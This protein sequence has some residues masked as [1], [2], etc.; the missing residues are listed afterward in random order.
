MATRYCVKP[1]KG[2]SPLT[3]VST[4]ACRKLKVKL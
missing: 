1:L 4:V 2:M 3:K